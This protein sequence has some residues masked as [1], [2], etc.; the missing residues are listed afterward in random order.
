MIESAAGFFTYFVVMAQNGFTPMKLL[1]IG[2][3]WD[4]EAINDLEDSYGQEWVSA[5]K[6]IKRS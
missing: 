4:D 2:K 6:N 5:L 3:Y 1:E